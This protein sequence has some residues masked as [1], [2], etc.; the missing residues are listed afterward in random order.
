VRP[1]SALCAAQRRQRSADRGATSDSV[2]PI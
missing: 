2:G 1:R